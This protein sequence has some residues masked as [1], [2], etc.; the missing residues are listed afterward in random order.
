MKKRMLSL[1]LAAVLVWSS[2]PVHSFAVQTEKT[3]YQVEA[4]ASPNA[5]VY[6]VGDTVTVRIKVSSNDSTVRLYSAYDL[7]ISYDTDVLTY[8]SA[9][10][11]DADAEITE[12]NGSI[13]IKGYGKDKAFSTAAVSLIFEIKT[14]GEGT[15]TVEEA[16]I[17]RSENAGIQNA[18]EAGLPEKPVVI[19]AQQFYKVTLKGNGLVADSR[20][21]SPE[22]DYSFR[23]VDPNLFDYTVKVLSGS[24]DI[25]SRVKYDAQT[26]TYTIPKE[27]IIGD[28]AITATRTPKE[29]EP[30]D[31]TDPTDPKPTDPTDPKPTDPTDP[32]PTNPTKPTTKPTNPTTKPTTSTKP[33]Q[34]TTTQTTTATVKAVTYLTMDGTN[35]YMILYKDV[36]PQG[37]VPKYDG[38]NMYWSEEYHAYVWLLTDTA[39]RDDVEM[40]AK[41]KVSVSEGSIAGT[42]NYSGN[43]DL[44]L[45]TDTKD[46]QLVWDL[47]N[48]K[49]T[50]DNMEMLKFLNAD[51]NADQKLD[52]RDAAAVVKIILKS[53]EEQT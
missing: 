11:A 14:V 5:Q 31:P 12:D 32:K 35:M 7:K 38:N 19:V 49:Y 20:V 22:K 45:H 21:A 50:L 18:P 46:V 8:D 51:L 28:I 33:S 6:S 24:L 41:G 13:R 43:V 17:D 48:V 34:S 42:V 3:E 29:T 53:E 10:A 30:T 16:K 52:I 9:I 44:S 26:G 1:L 39:E 4:A 25:T 40:L 47:Y 2:F 37:K 23:V 27:H 36:I 15:V